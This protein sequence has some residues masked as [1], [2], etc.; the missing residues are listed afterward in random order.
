MGRIR[1]SLLLRA[2]YLSL[3]TLFAGLTMTGAYAGQV[4]EKQ[5]VTIDPTYYEST[6]PL[7]PGA[8]VGAP[9]SDELPANDPRALAPGRTSVLVHMAPN[10]GPQSNERA[11]VR[12]FAAQRGGVVKHE[13]AVLPNVINIRDIP[14]TA[15]DALKQSPGVVK[16]EIDEYHPNLLRL[17]DS[18][19][20]ING[21]QSQISAAGFSAD[22]SGVRVCICDTGIDSDHIMY[23]SRIDAS[24]GF[25]FYNDDND[26]EDDNGHGSHVA[27]IA[28]GGTGL[29]VDFGCGAGAQDFQGVAPNATL[30]GAK[31]L[32]E[33][34]GGFDSD[35]I[36]GID[37]CAD[38]SASG[39]QADVIN[40]SIG[41]GQFSS[42]CS[43]SW[44]VAANNAV[45]NGVVVVAASGNENYSNAVSSPAC[46]SDVI[47]VGATWKADYPTCEDNTTNWNWGV[48]TD[49]SPQTDDV[50]CF[51]NESD[52]LDVAAPGLN[53]WSASNDAGGSSIV[54]QSGTS[55]ASPHVAGLAALILEADP[56]LT[57]AEVRQIIRDGA[58]D[59]GPI[60]VI[61]S[62]SLVGPGCT[63]NA[64]CDDADACTIDSCDSG[65]C[66]NTPISCD[67]SDACTTDSCN[68]INGCAN[69][70]INCDDGDPCTTDSCDPA[71]GC[72]NV[73]PACY[74]NDGCCPTGCDNANDNDC[75]S[76]V[77]GNGVCESG[78]DCNT[79][80]TDCFAG[81]GAS[82]GNGVC[83]A[84]DGE[85]CKSCAADCNGKQNGRP[86]DRF[87]CGDGDGQ[88]PVGCGDSRCT[89]SGNTC[90]DTP[91][92]GSCC[93]D[94]ICEGT[95]DGANC[96]VDCAAC[97][98]NADCD[99]GD[100]CT[101]D[102][103]SSGSC[104]NTPINCD[105]GD[106]CTTDSCSGGTCF[107]NPISCD[108]GDLCT[109][110]SCDSVSGCANTPINCD[111][112][113]PCTSDSCDSGTGTCVNDPVTPCCGDTFCDPGED[114]C[115][116]PA[117]CG[118]PPSVESN[119][120]DGIDEDC[121]GQVDCADSDCADDSACSS[122]TV[123]GNGVCEGNGEDCFSC[124]SDCRCAGPNCNA[125][126]GDGICGGNGENPNNCPVDC[127]G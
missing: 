29:T 24:A 42:N 85:D 40:L 95:E 4:T 43:H 117:D 87:C 16:V 127:G 125:C 11:N 12:A 80:A 50:G 35:I 59:L 83:E 13:Y 84:G 19:P 37:H 52:L 20:L 57:P 17:H 34:G 93:G 89:G 53:I 122:G 123:C 39:G 96:A 55:M 60:E 75:P 79:C 56:G 28:V 104:S 49:S 77:C 120:T 51:S 23:S 36:A 111:D 115:S 94:G 116:C 3:A 68:P 62:L 65:T 121:D 110:D 46:G 97:I 63:T 100:S 18:V 6:E 9:T 25:D 69:D 103:C 26:P 124:S 66:S 38:Q 91:S 5:Q 44:A 108:D 86:S 102:V 112:G 8:V 82:C 14:K 88:N 1:S 114:Q 32:N 45:A 7:T 10:A 78:E 30:I 64:D 22:G 113:D 21:L 27:G 106:A 47:A 107:N 90:T 99:D 105:D 126:C 98:T 119:C 76:F 101:T 48:C 81:S 41:T 58:I 70:P 74:D 54:G 61:N 73:E 92:V 72:Q 109:T 15:V 71:S 31:I 33:F 67:D 118:T 2:P